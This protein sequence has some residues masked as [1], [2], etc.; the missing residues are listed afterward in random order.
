M[1]SASM[2]AKP[3]IMGSWILGA[4]LGLRPMLSI[5]AAAMRPWPRAAPKAARP[6]AKPAAIAMA[7]FAPTAPSAASAAAIATPESRRPRATTPRTNSNFFIPASF[8]ANTGS[9]LSHP[10]RTRALRLML[11]AYRH[12]HINHAQQ[13]KDKGLDHR[14]QGPQNVKKYRDSNLSQ[15]GKDLHDQVVAKHVAKKP[16]RKGKRA[17]EMGDPFEA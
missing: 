1:A 4:A 17:H 7:A 16:Q 12:G 14:D 10:P 15:I 5:A 13:C 2:K 9:P 11:M 6:M 8:L 3:R